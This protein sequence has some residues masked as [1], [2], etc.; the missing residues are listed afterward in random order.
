MNVPILHH[1]PQSPVAEKVRVVLGIKDL[2]WK[3]VQIPRLPPK[4][5]LMPLTGGYRKTPV[6]QI[7]AN[8]YCDSRCIIT[9][10]ECRYPAPSLWP[11]QGGALLFGL[12]RWTDELLFKETIAL[13]LG[14]Q[15]DSLDPAFA[16]DRGRL[17]FGA[18][19][20]LAAM[21]RDVPHVL[22][23]LATQFSWVDAQLRES[24]GAYMLGE[25]PGYLDVLV[26]CLVW[27]VRGR[28]TH[29]EDLL[30]PYAAL[31]SWEQVM[32][33]IGHGRP[34]NLSA[35]GALQTAAR[36]VSDFHG[37]VDPK[38]PQG[39][40]AGQTVTVTPSEGGPSVAG[41]LM[42]LDRERVALLRTD[43]RLG[44]VVVHFPRIGYRIAP[45]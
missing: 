39:F 30:A 41:S 10:L 12:A 45:A 38:D 42:H 13:V 2:E 24:E 26:Y 23:Q 37:E 11:A 7:G 43:P 19:F 4:P 34:R 17:Y 40:G 36:A 28:F 8:V 29:A 3:S 6:L 31:R 15:A 1:Y 21:H 33:D 32:V 9:E 25:A 18:D 16:K 27:F 14:A 22:G 44:E 20:D 5:E 35:Q